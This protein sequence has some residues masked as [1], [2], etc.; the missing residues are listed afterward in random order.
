[1]HIIIPLLRAVGFDGQEIAHGMG[2]AC[3]HHH[4]LSL[5]LHGR[6]RY[7]A[8]LLYDDGALLI[9]DVLVVVMKSLHSPCGWCLFIFRVF[10]NTFCNLIRYIIRRVAQQHIFNKTFLDGL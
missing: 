6:Q 3:R 2:T 4:R 5:S 7:L 1:M 8:E 10:S 9:N